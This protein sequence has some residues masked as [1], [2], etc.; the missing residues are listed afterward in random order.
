MGEIQRQIGTRH[1][2]QREKV[3]VYLG[4]YR[5]RRGRGEGGRAE[6]E[7]GR[8]SKRET[9]RGRGKKRGEATFWERWK[10]ERAQAGNRRN[11]HLTT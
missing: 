4:G 2:M 7:R 3:G 5:E 9:E 8:E 10:R 1:A 11:I 6:R